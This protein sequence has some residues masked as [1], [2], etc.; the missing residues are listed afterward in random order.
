MKEILLK[1]LVSTGRFLL[2]RRNRLTLYLLAIAIISFWD[3][4]QIDYSR[5]TY[6]FYTS[7]EDSIFI[8]ERMLP[9][10]ED[11]ET[12]IRWYIEEA[13]FGPASHGLE[14]LFPRE[15]RLHSF[16]L[17]DAVVYANFTESA[18]LP[19]PGNGDVQRSFLSLNEGIRRNFPYVKD[20]KLF[21]GGIEVFFKLF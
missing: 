7:L 20:V 12:E 14:P 1:I 3:Y 8:E 15:T 13:L 2:E 6:I 17:R 4:S 18:L 21:I 19:I 10:T 11:Q 16:M 9:N 5:R